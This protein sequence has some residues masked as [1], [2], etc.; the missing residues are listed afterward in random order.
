MTNFG[1]VVAA[2]EELGIGM[3]ST[4]PWRIPKDMAFFKHV[5]MHVP[6]E[7]P[8]NQTTPQ[9]AVIM[10]R[11]T[12]E[13]IPPKFRPLSE[14]FNIVVSRNPTYDLQLANA[15]QPSTLLVSSLEEA[16]AAVDPQQ[17]PRCFVI[18]GA[19]MYRLA[20]KHATCTHILLTRVK[21]K[22]DC[23]TFFPEINETDY[24]LASHEEM[25]AYVEQEVP[26]GLQTHKD[27]E[28]EFTM[29]IRRSFQPVSPTIENHPA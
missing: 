29:Y 26:R 12:W 18:G 20:I 2:T 9:N 17:H 4:L 6:K 8:S 5:T 11:V 10:G 3:L 24:R 14:R 15:Q 19:Q 25:E 7:F 22:V 1:L 28:Y 13:S 21:S 16:F 27:L 23:D